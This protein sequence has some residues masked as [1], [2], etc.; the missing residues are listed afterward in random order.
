MSTK[1]SFEIRK[2]VGKATPEVR[3]AF[4]ERFNDHVRF[5]EPLAKYLAYGIGGPADILVFPRGAEDLEW[6]AVT[7]RTF[8]LPVTIVGNGTNL[9]VVDDGLRGVVLSL[10][11]SFLEI[12]KLGTVGGK[13]QVRCGGGVKKPDVLE[14][15]MNQHLSGLEFSS[16]V[17][18]TLGGGIYMNAG[19]KYGCYADVLVELQLFDFERGLR[20]L[21]RKDLYFGYREQT[22][23]GDSL[24]VSMVFELQAGDGTAIR[25]EVNRIIAERAEKQPLDFPSCGSTFKNPPEG[26]SAGRLIERAGLKGTQVGGAEISLKHANFILNKNSAKAKDILAL[27]DIIKKRV[28]EQFQVHLECEVIILGEIPIEPANQIQNPH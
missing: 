17:P 14:W 16:G 2:G 20:T 24:V 9:L 26:L 4:A 22:A 5:D 1:S 27:I 7:C 12:E 28:F 18:G 6:L 3:N 15:A 10:S 13:T 8:D 21:A 11:R 25:T 19:T 23:V